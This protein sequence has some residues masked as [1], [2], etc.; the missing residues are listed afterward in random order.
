MR[1]VSNQ[2]QVIMGHIWYILQCLFTSSCS[3]M[4]K[5]ITS[6][7]ILHPQACRLAQSVARI[8]GQT[9]QLGPTFV[10]TCLLVSSVTVL[11]FIISWCWP[12]L[13]K[14]FLLGPHRSRRNHYGESTTQLFYKWWQRQIASKGESPKRRTWNKAQY[15]LGQYGPLH[16]LWQVSFGCWVR[17]CKFVFIF[18]TKNKLT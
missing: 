10:Q 8:F 11:W 4:I 14:I 9:C 5:S 12:S 7:W 2:E 18:I 3:V 13:D 16:V 6:V 17:K 15:I 1:A